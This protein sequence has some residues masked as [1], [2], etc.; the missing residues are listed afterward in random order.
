MLPLGLHALDKDSM[1]SDTTLS[2]VL[3]SIPMLPVD[4]DDRDDTSGSF[5][6]ADN[7]PTGLVE[8]FS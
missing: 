6:F 3:L 1:H 4:G 7:S 5:W 8:I 2:L